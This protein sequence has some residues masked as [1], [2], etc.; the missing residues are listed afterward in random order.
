MLPQNHPA[1]DFAGVAPRSSPSGE[2]MLARRKAAQK[3][4]SPIKKLDYFLFC[5]KLKI[6][7]LKIM[8]L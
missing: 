3:V 1:S 8:A 2:T 4:Y 7:S 6:D 5:V